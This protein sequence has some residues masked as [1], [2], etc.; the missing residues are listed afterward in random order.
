MKKDGDRQSAS[1]PAS[2]TKSTYPLQYYFELRT[3]DAATLY[4]PF[5]ATFSNQPYFA[6]MPSK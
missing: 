3:T 6:I 5:N 1:I 2:Y 4:P